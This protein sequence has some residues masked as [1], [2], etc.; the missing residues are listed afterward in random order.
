MA[1]SDFKLY[2]FFEVELNGLTSEFRK[3]KFGGE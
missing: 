2:F 3:N 1:G